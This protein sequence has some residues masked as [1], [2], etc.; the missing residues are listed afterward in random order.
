MKS[1]QKGIK[2]RSQDSEK[3]RK[4]TSFMNNNSLNRFQKSN[5]LYFRSLEQVVSHRESTSLFYFDLFVIVDGLLITS[6]YELIVVKGG[7]K[8]RKFCTT[9]SSLKVYGRR[10]FCCK[11]CRDCFLLSLMLSCK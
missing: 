10:S 6:S 8:K 2:K 11:S 5:S 9:R 7:R 4:E 1:L 3:K